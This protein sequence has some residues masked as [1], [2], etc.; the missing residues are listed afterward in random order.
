MGPAGVLPFRFLSGERKRKA[1]LPCSAVPRV[2]LTWANE[3]PGVRSVVPSCDARVE[4][5]TFRY[6]CLTV[7]T[8]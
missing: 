1:L 7:R 3:R 4:L 2:A 8:H 6:L 5:C